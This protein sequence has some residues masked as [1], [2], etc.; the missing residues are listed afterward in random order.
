MI[1]ISN[2]TDVLKIQAGSRAHT[3]WEQAAF[4]GDGG[5]GKTIVTGV[6]KLFWVI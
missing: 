4:L 6:H 3:N 2:D 5:G 1:L